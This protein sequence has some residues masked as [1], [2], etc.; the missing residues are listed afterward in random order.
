MSTGRVLIIDNDEWL[1]L[2]ISAGLRKGGYEV[3]SAA[4]GVTGVALVKQFRPN[5]VICSAELSDLSGLWVTRKIRTDSSDLSSIPIVLLMEND[6]SSMMQ[7]SFSVGADACLVRSFRVDEIVQQMGALV[8]MSDR[9]RAV[10]VSVD[11]LRP[12]AGAPEPSALS[13]ELSQISLGTVLTILEMERRSG[14]LSVENDGRRGALELSSGYATRGQIGDV[15]VSPLSVLREA[16]RWQKGTFVFR[17]SQTPSTSEIRKSI[18]ALLIEAVRLDDEKAYGDPWKDLTSPGFE[19]ATSPATAPAMALAP[20]PPRPQPS[21]HAKVAAVARRSR[22]PLASPSLRMGPP[23]LP[24]V[25]KR[26]RSA[27]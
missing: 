5:G 12:I 4:D 21:G 10:D 6:D 15:Q 20:T 2:L 9:L 18:G 8:R 17:T 23:P 25:S 7:Q 13:G 19:P 1:A 26:P 11:S 14:E 16:L 24:I 27:V 3:E 22:P